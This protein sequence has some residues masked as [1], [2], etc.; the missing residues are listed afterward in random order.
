MILRRAPRTPR[1][2]AAAFVVAVLLGFVAGVVVLGA[3][4]GAKN[5][6]SLSEALP[7]A[8]TRFEQA[9]LIGPV[10]RDH[11]AATWAKEKLDELPN[12]LSKGRNSATLIPS[13]GA[14]FG[15][16]FWTL[17]LTVALLIDGPRFIAEL[18]KLLL[19]RYR[20]QFGT[21][22]SISHEA[23]GGYLAGA[24]IIA[25]LDA[26]VVLVTALALQ[27][28]LAPALAGWAFLTNF[29][30][31]IG[32]LLG[33]APLVLLAFTV[34]PVQAAIAGAVFV[35]YQFLE[36]H[37]IGPRIISRAVDISPVASLLA[38][39]IG[40]AAAGV[41]GALLLTPIVGV[42]KVVRELADRGEIPG[43][44]VLLRQSS[45]DSATFR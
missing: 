23:V 3:Q 30:P 6:V 11:D 35:I 27:V 15:D 32:G 18:R 45:P 40:A 22:V 5:N 39:L 42:Y 24:T 25:A 8:V 1:S 10:L 43:Q 26:L 36:N 29:L 13:I 16:L 7:R 38:A 9:P 21:F 17:A 2:V 12:L 20:R 31:Q 28:P 33:G 4:G 37:I 34:G 14:R 44:Q 19:V 41:L